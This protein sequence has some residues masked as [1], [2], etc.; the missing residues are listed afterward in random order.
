[1]KNHLTKSLLLLAVLFSAIPVWAYDFS[2][3]NEDGKPVAIS[4]KAC[5]WL[6]YLNC[7]KNLSIRIT[8]E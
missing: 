4:P 6:N 5:V 2:E 1:M 3:V 8:T 7:T